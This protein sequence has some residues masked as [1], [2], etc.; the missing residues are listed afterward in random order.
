MKKCIRVVLIFSVIGIGISSCIK[1][2]TAVPNCLPL[3]KTAPAS[4]VAILKGYIDSN[5]IV[6]IQDSR[7]FF[8]SIDSSASTDTAHPTTC[9]GVSVTYTGTFLN[10]TVFDSTGAGTPASFN[11]SGT[12]IGWQEALPLM[13]ANANMALYLPP[14]LAYGASGYSR[15]PGNSYLIFKIK[16]LAFN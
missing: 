10:G 8:Y 12:I 6:A 1:N 9:S 2:D 7:G 11:L 5:H 16:L 3:T 13:K 4:E 15:I 14:S